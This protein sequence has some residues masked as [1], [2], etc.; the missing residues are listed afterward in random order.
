M[1]VFIELWWRWVQSWQ[2][3]DLL[4]YEVCGLEVAVVIVFGTHRQWF[5]P[6]ASAGPSLLIFVSLKPRPGCICPSSFPRYLDNQ[7]NAC[8]EV[9]LHAKSRGYGEVSVSPQRL[10][11]ASPVAW[12]GVPNHGFGQKLERLKSGWPH[13]TLQYHHAFRVPGV[14]PS[15]CFS[16]KLEPTWQSSK[17]RLIFQITDLFELTP[18]HRI[19]VWGC[20]RH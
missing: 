2:E 15:L 13:S 18:G 7:P 8:I 1:Q 20:C 6:R 19:L 11:P 5:A 10:L 3:C 17:S 14:F 12:L 4:F 16:T 9:I